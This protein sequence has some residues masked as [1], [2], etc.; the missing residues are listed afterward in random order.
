MVSSTARHIGVKNAKLEALTPYKNIPDRNQHIDILNKIEKTRENLPKE[1]H[2]ILDD[3]KKDVENFD[4]AT[5]S[6]RADALNNQIP[7]ALNFEKLSKDLFP[8]LD[9]LNDA[10]II[11]DLKRERMVGRYTQRISMDPETGR[12]IRQTFDTWDS[13]NQRFYPDFEEKLIGAESLEKGK[14]GLN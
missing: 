7:D 4:Y 13:Q 8:M 11:F 10:I 9:P 5:A 3:I 1:Y 2:S 12:G 6:N 14:G